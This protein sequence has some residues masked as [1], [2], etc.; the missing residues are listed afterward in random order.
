MKNIPL[1]NLV[2]QTVLDQMRA[3]ASFTALDIS[4]ALKLDCFPVQHREV[5]ASVRE[6]YESGAM[7]FYNYERETIP[8]V[9]ANG[10]AQARAF[11]YHY[12]EVKPRTYQTRDQ[13]ALPAVAP[14]LARDLSESAPAGP[15]AIL[16]RPARLPSAMPR[17]RAPRRRTRRDGAL[18]VPKL[19]VARLGWSDGTRLTL[20]QDG[21]SVV[22]EAAAP[23]S[24]PGPSLTVWHGQR[25]RISRTK[26]SLGALSADTVMIETLQDGLRVKHGQ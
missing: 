3:K 19:L 6:I 21:N 2:E 12:G 24:S 5:A 17:S 26:L 25:L 10:T 1:T 7:A 14:G 11:L 18:A 20:R 8:V 13:D 9:T 15:A 16:P 22:I 23:L 4:N